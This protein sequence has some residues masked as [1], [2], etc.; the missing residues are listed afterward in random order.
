MS[1]ADFHITTNPTDAL[2]GNAVTVVGCERQ[3][4]GDLR[5]YIGLR[6][7]GVYVLLRAG[8]AA[9][10]AERRW[11]GTNTTGWMWI[12]PPPPDH[13]LHIDKPVTT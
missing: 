12:T 13:A 4:D 11:H 7:K 3:D 1:D 8:D 5:L 10:G 6:S 2:I 9:D